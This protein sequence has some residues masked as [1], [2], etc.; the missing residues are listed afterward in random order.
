MNRDHADALVTFARV[1]A[2]APAADTRELVGWILSF[3][4]GVKVVRPAELRD[5]VR[6]EALAV[7]RH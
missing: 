4:L 7:S 1:L 2:G 6:Q 5:R 3:G